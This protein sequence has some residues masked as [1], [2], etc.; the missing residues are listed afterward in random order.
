MSADSLAVALMAIDDP[1]VREKVKAGDFSG[2]HPDVQLTSGEQELVKAA[3]AE[4]VDPEVAGFD[5]ANSAFF[6]A[7][8][9]VPG[10][11][12]SGPVAH[13]FQGFMQDKFAGI[14]GSMATGCA[15]PP[16]SS[17]GFAGFE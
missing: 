8:S 16:M 11:V 10:N 12:L 7:A 3:A 4:E 14:G 17:I 13:S 5:A 9:M 6:H 1:A 2:L 15:C